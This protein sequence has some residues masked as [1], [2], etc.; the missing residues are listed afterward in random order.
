V[1]LLKESLVTLLKP[2]EL[3]LY[4]MGVM[5]RL[6][7]NES[8]RLGLSSRIAH[9]YNQLHG[10][11]ARLLGSHTVGPALQTAWT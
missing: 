10:L 9:R 8:V 4:A 7:C 2:R 5:N 1:S 3:D 11:S 6:P